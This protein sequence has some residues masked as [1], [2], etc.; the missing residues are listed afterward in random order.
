MLWWYNK[1][2]ILNLQEKSLNL[3]PVKET[4]QMKHSAGFL[5]TSKVHMLQF[6]ASPHQNTDQATLWTSAS[7]F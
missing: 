4:V 5:L 3:M 6:C 1:S 7:G 2:A